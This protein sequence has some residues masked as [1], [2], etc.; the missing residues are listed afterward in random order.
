MTL[1][2]YWETMPARCAH[3]LVMARAVLADLSAR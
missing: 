2:Y 1:P 3:R